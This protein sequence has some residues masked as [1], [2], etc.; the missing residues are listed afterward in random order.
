M[1]GCKDCGAGSGSPPAPNI[2]G[3]AQSG[4]GLTGAS[5]DSNITLKDTQ[6][7]VGLA[8]WQAPDLSKSVQ[9]CLT[10]QEREAAVIRATSYCTVALRLLNTEPWPPWQEYLFAWMPP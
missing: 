6:L 1:Q 8:A 9:Q 10:V 2:S 4:A 3:T 5:T 7:H